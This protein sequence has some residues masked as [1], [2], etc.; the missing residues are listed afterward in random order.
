MTNEDRREPRVIEQR[1]VPA[2]V[3]SLRLRLTQAPPSS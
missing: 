1:P 3:S 2:Y